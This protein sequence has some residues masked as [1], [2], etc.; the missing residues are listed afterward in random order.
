MWELRI[1]LNLKQIKTYFNRASSRARHSAHT[2]LPEVNFWMLF[3][4]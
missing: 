1:D 2:Q 3:I 4:Q